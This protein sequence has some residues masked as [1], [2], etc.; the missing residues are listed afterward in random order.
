MFVFSVIVFIFPFL[1]VTI[2]GMLF[3]TLFIILRFI[4]YS[5]RSKS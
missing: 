1:V 2:R 4:L 5:H 3:L